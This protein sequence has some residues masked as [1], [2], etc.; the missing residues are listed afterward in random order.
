[1]WAVV[2]VYSEEGSPQVCTFVVGLTKPVISAGGNGMERVLPK[3]L[4]AS[5]G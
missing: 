3:R 1:M 4:K 2:T 5:I